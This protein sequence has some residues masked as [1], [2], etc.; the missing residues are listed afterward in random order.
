MELLNDRSPARIPAAA[1]ITAWELTR[2]NISAASGGGF[3]TLYGTY[4]DTIFFVGTLTEKI[5]RNGQ[6]SSLRVSDPTG[7]LTFSL[8]PQDTVLLRTA[9]ALDVPCFV[10]ITA[11][12]RL[13]AYAGKSYI[14]LSPETLTPADRKTRDAWLCCAADEALSRITSLSPSTDR[15]E[16]ADVL[17]DALANVRDESPVPEKTQPE[18]TDEQ[19][20]AIILELSGKRGAPIFEVVSRLGALGM[21]EA[22]A[23]AALARLMEE[24][25]CYTPTTELIKVA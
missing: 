5:Q 13:R 16:F 20:L 7:V 12:V 3:C 6:I 15:K 10:A 1:C 9:D 23:K 18:V 19:I 25:E 8:S 17:T 22:D 21:G 14:E 4:S 24:G 11:S 2:K